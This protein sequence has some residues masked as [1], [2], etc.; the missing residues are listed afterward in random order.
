MK[1]RDRGK[2]GM[3]ASLTTA[4]KQERQGS[5]MQI[6]MPSRPS[7]PSIALL[8]SCW[9]TDGHMLHLPCLWRSDC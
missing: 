8:L 9:T 3:K 6:P 2:D 7:N 1:C 4:S 5:P